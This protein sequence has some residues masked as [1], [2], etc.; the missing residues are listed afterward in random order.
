MPDTQSPEIQSDRNA[1]TVW[2]LIM[3]FRVTQLLHVAA[4]L[5]VADHLHTPRTP[6][7][8][9][10]RVGADP[11]ALHRILRALASLGIFSE[12]TDVAF[13]LTPLPELLRS[14][15]PGSLRGAALIYGEEWLWAR[16]WPHVA[17][18]RDRRAGLRLEPPSNS[19]QSASPR[20]GRREGTAPAEGPDSG[21]RER[22]A[23]PPD[24]TG[25]QDAQH[26]PH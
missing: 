2:Q 13:T 25:I 3:G 15:A 9:A 18:R 11:G 10:S 1:A 19:A 8:L 12:R 24:A 5:G 17:Q 21:R 22:R 14:D 6:D 20:A 7:E 23:F 26:Y 16:L 4:K